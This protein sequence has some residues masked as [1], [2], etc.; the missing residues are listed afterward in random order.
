MWA[1]DGSGSG[2]SAKLC[3]IG[4]RVRRGATLHGLALN[5]T[6][7]LGYFSLIVPC[8]LQCRPVTSVRKITGGDAPPMDLVK[9]AV[10]RSLVSSL[11]KRP[12]EVL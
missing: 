7:D 6:T 9:E 2:T 5:V 10:A 11:S 4:V 3:A 8:G 12:A 1:D